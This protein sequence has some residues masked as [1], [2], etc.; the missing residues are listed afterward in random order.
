MGTKSGISHTAL[1]PR[2]VLCYSALFSLVFD[3]VILQVSVCMFHPVH[4]FIFHVCPTFFLVMS[5]VSTSTISG[6]CAEIKPFCQSKLSVSF[7]CPRFWQW[8][9]WPC[10]CQ[11]CLQC[12]GL[13]DALNT[14]SQKPLHFSLLPKTPADF[15]EPSQQSLVM[16]LTLALP[17]LSK[18]EISTL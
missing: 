15:L 7:S 1:T 14:E 9:A 6:L 16:H 4:V 18:L 5:T 11:R 12:S 13:S 17:F 2:W 10:P 8:P 3:N